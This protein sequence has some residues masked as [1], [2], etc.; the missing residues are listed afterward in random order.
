M[1]NMDAKSILQ[2]QHQ[3]H[4]SSS[5]Y[6]Q[7]GLLNTLS[8]QNVQ[9]EQFRRLGKAHTDHASENKREMSGDDKHRQTITYNDNEIFVF[10]LF[11][12]LGK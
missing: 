11:S 6:N 9:T 1:R 3:H 10:E 12:F 7:T 5:S 8:V 2:Q 4:Q